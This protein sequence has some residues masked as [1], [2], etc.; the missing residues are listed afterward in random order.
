M[1]LGVNQTEML[2][3]EVMLSQVEKVVVTGMAIQIESH[4]IQEWYLFPCSTCPAT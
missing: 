4:A 3:L 1:V 2:Y